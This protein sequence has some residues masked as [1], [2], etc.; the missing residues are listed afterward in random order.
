M[1]I[2]NLLLEKLKKLV[3]QPLIFALLLAGCLTIIL[4]PSLEG[5]NPNNWLDADNFDGYRYVLGQHG[6]KSLAGDE[7]GV[8]STLAT[9]SGWS[10]NENTATIFNPKKH[11]DLRGYFA[12]LA[13]D[14]GYIG[15]WSKLDNSNKLLE[16]R[17]PLVVEVDSPEPHLII[18]LTIENNYL[19][20]A[21]PTVG[22]VLYPLKNFYRTWTGQI[23]QLEFP[24]LGS[25]F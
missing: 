19:Y 9:L 21:D 8:Q 7:T 5:S 24:D 17:T 25:P 6:I 2:H 16:I 1:Q 22:N 4:W 18:V 12:E 20:G 23:Y 14:Q 10:L 11:N 13:K 3:D 15:S